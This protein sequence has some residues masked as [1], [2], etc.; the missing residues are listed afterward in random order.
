[1]DECVQR[2]ELPTEDDI[3][4][5]AIMNDEAYLEENNDEKLPLTKPTK[6]E[7]AAFEII[8]KAL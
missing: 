4:E 1:M 7:Y 2:F 6:N 5:K 8:R 3:I